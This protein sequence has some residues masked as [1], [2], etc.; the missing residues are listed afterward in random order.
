MFLEEGDIRVFK[1]EFKLVTIVMTIIQ[2]IT[3]LTLL[4]ECK[5]VYQDFKETDGTIT[6]LKVLRPTSDC[7]TMYVLHTRMFYGR[8]WESTEFWY[9]IPYAIEECLW[10]DPVLIKSVLKPTPSKF[11][12]NIQRSLPFYEVGMMQHISRH[13]T[14]SSIISMIDNLEDA[15][16][17]HIVLPLFPKDLLDKAIEIYRFRDSTVQPIFKQIVEALLHLK[18]VCHVAHHDVSLENI[19]LTET[20][21][22]ILCDFGLS[23]MVLSC[24]STEKM[25][26]N[27]VNKNRFYGGKVGYIAPEME[28]M[29]PECDLFAADVWSLGVCLCNLLTGH[30]LY[31]NTDDMNFF[32]LKH[33]GVRNILN[34]T[35]L[36]AAAK[37][38]LCQ[39]LNPKPDKRIT[40]EEVLEHPFTQGKT[41]EFKPR[42]TDTMC[43]KLFSFHSWVTATVNKYVISNCVIGLSC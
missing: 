40:L 7:G 9:A 35:R 4:T 27:S 23:L 13:P 37:D 19:L 26:L 33:G 15:T 16:H 38:L 8:G 10:S 6:K 29:R 36:S 30:P 11:H 18:D 32:H 22:P 31:T 41:E 39:M 14:H 12:K 17:V 3:P 1:S 2:N 5:L 43:D 34:R 28:S 20:N 21:Q 42:N 24:P 25:T